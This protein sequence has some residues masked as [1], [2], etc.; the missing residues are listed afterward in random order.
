LEFLQEVGTVDESGYVNDESYQ[1]LTFDLVS[2][3]S[4]HPSW[5][6][7]VYEAESFADDS[8][9]KEEQI[10][11]TEAKKVYKNYLLSELKK[12]FK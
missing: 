12:M 4:N 5:V 11:E 2:N 10:S 6:K 9:K 7:G 8:I 1:L 3:P